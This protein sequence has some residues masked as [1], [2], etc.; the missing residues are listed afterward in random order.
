VVVPTKGDE[1]SKS[2]ES[3][4]AQEEFCDRDFNISRPVRVLDY[5]GSFTCE[6]ID[7][8]PKNNIFDLNSLVGLLSQDRK[9]ESKTMLIPTRIS[10]ASFYCTREC[11]RSWEL[12]F[13]HEEYSDKEIVCGYPLKVVLE[14][15]FSMIESYDPSNSTN[16]PSSIKSRLAKCSPDKNSSEFYVVGKPTIQHLE[17]ENGYFVVYVDVRSP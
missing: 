2:S 4:I 15:N 12:D 3:A 1:V 8:T 5:E 10:D 9:T 13:S 6:P 11:S 17:V 14:Y 7:T 16:P